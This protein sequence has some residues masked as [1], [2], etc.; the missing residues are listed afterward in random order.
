MIP[1]IA[2]KLYEG[3]VKTHSEAELIKEN[4]T[5]ESLKTILMLELK[6]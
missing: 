6:A 3:F 1:D 5:I 2:K 4:I